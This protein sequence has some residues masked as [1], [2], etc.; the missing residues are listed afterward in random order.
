LLEADWLK[1]GQRLDILK[2]LCLTAKANGEQHELKEYSEALLKILD[3]Q[4]NCAASGG[5]RRH[6]ILSKG[7]TLDELEEHERALECYRRCVEACERANDRDGLIES[8]WSIAQAL[9]K[10][11]RREQERQAYEKI[12]SLDGGTSDDFHFPMALTMLA[13]L[14]IMEQRFDDARARLDHAERENEH[15]RNPLVGF[16]VKDLRD[17]LP[18]TGNAKGRWLIHDRG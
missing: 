5:E 12:L 8:W 10:G 7:H 13:Q 4:I 2:I 18:A 9:G 16:L 3:D 1:P 11:K 17:K 15:Q 14:D 6:L